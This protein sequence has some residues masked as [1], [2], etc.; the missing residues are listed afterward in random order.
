[1]GKTLIFTIN[2]KVFAFLPDSPLSFCGLETQI[3]GT[4]LGVMK[5]ANLFCYIV[6]ERPEKV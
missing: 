6:G 5:S 2:V 1:M 4:W 3:A